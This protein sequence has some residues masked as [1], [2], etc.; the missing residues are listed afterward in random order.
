[1]AKTIVVRY[2][3]ELLRIDVDTATVLDVFD[4]LEGLEEL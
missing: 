2:G 4:P 3:G 1:M